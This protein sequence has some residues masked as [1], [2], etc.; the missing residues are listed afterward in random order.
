MMVICDNCGKHNAELEK[1]Y[2]DLKILKDIA[3]N[4]EARQARKV[5]DLESVIEELA[6][7]IKRMQPNVRTTARI[8]EDAI[9]RAK[10]E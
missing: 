4:D 1:H 3:R 7:E 6:K 10:G 8:V 9:E 5:A 2:E